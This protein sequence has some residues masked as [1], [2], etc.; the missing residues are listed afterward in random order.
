[1]N[2]GL[3]NSQD[4]SAELPKSDPT[5]TVSPDKMNQGEGAHSG[6]DSPQKVD[7]KRRIKGSHR[8]GTPPKLK[9]L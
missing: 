4:N 8:G 1:M 6:S 5:D 2:D 9:W 3:N 7:T